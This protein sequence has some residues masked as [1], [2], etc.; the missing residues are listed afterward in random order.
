MKSFFSLAALVLAL[1]IGAACRAEKSSDAPAAQEG[2]EPAKTDQIILRVGDSLYH[3]S[4]FDEYVRVEV[5]TG[6]TS[7]ESA[8]L[9]SLFDEFIDDRLLLNEATNQNITISAEEKA[10][11]L[12]KLGE[13]TLTEEEKKSFLAAQSGPMLDKLL[14]DKYVH[15]LTKDIKVEE[16]EIRD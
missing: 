1:L 10:Q 7:M 3:D 4:D 6:M 9:S 14:I 2:A 13:G 12:A 15:E 11:Y 8:T 16:E 5:G